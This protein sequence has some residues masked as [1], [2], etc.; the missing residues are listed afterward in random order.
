MNTSQRPAGCTGQ[1]AERDPPRLK[2]AIPLAHPLPRSWLRPQTS[3]PTEP[4]EC[5]GWPRLT[6]LRPFQHGWNDKGTQLPSQV[7]R[8]HRY[9]RNSPRQL[10]SAWTHVISND[11]DRMRLTTSG[12]DCTA[13]HCVRARHRQRSARR[14]ALSFLSGPG[15]S[16]RI[17]HG[18]LTSCR[19][20]EWVSRED[21]D[22]RIRIRINDATCRRSNNEIQSPTAISQNFHFSPHD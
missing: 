1:A 21:R 4:L 19:T 12:W 9:D 14:L 5:P 13:V 11:P 10:R 20:S 8:N 6:S 7:R 15:A 3:G 18:Q 22:G 17:C 2:A 16:V